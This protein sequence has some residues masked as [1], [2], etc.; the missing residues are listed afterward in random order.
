MSAASSIPSLAILAALAISAVAAA[1]LLLY[2]RDRYA[3]SQGKS[4]E[5][6][7]A[8]I[9]ALVQ[10]YRT[11]ECCVPGALMII[12]GAFLAFDRSR[13]HDPEW[14]IGLLLI[15]LGWLAVWLLAR[16]SWRRYLELQR[17]AAGKPSHADER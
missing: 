9:L 15:P 3:A 7:Q 1:A 17:R 8:R 10:F 6:V 11:L 2:L 4:I 14:P 13:E 5:Q 12:G 16:K